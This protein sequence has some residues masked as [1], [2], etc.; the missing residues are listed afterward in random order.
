VL[1]VS[2]E[3]LD[4][5]RGKLSQSDQLQGAIASAEFPLPPDFSVDEIGGR[6]RAGSGGGGGRKG[7]RDRRADECSSDMLHSDRKRRGEELARHLAVPSTALYCDYWIREEW[8][9]RARWQQRAGPAGGLAGGEGAPL[10]G[11][12]GAHGH[13][14]H[15]LRGVPRGVQ[16]DT[17]ACPRGVHDD[18]APPADATWGND[19]RGRRVLPPPWTRGPS[20][21][22]GRE[23]RRRQGGGWTSRGQREGRSRGAWKVLVSARSGRQITR[24][25]LARLKN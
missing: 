20:L 14:A 3:T 7:E 1:C 23:R 11:L 2:Q 18:D 13:R 22:W 16:D 24:I 17:D 15:D 21:P 5:L 12:P 25:M 19:G 10:P 6:R 4:S 8:Q 9:S